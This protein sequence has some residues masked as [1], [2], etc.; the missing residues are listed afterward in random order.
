[1]L[2]L[3]EIQDSWE[4]REK[5]KC[6]KEVK[7]MQVWLVVIGN[8]HHRRGLLRAISNEVKWFQYFTLFLFSGIVP[9]V[10]RPLKGRFIVFLQ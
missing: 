7:W 1:M 8:F 9:F 5:E 4:R 3:V 6:L 10:A 2:R